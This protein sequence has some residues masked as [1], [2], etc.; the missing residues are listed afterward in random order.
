MYV[1]KAR[2]AAIPLIC[3]EGLGVV[4]R[5]DKPPTPPYGDISVLLYQFNV[6]RDFAFEAIVMGNDEEGS[7][8]FAALILEELQDFFAVMI[9]QG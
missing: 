5:V 7:A 3:K 2:N 9:I 1:L 4:L 6:M 8:Y